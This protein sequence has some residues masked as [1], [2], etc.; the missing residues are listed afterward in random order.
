MARNLTWRREKKALL[1]EKDVPK[2]G[3]LD[4]PEQVKSPDSRRTSFGLSLDINR[5]QKDYIDIIPPKWSAISISLSENKH[6]LCITKMQA[7]QSPFIIRLPLER[8]N[9]RDADNEIFNFQQ[10]RTEI[11]E[12]I[13]LANET[14]HDA[15]DLSIKGAKSA[16][17][18]DRAALD[19]RMKDLLENIENI[20]LGGFKGIFSQHQRRSALLARFQKS[21]QNVLDKHLPSRRQVRGKRGK[22]VAP[23]VTLDPRILELFIG[24]GDATDPECDFDD[25]LNDLLY[26]VV[27]ILQF[28]GERNAYD[29]IDFDSMVVETFDALHSYHSAVKSEPEMEQGA[30]TIL[31]LDKALHVFPWE[32]L[33]CMQ[34]QA[35][36]RVP[37]LACLRRLILEQRS[38]TEDLDAGAESAKPSGHKVSVKSGS[39]I[40]NPGADLKTTQATFEKPLLSLGS[41]WKR[42]VSNKPTEA[43]FETALTDSDVLLYFGHGSGAQ[44]IRGRAIRKMEKC[45]A[46]VLLMGC[47]SARLADVGDFECHGPVWNYMLAGCP[48]VVG[49]LWDV[50]DRDIDRFAGRVF[51]EWGL[52]KKGTFAD[53]D[54]GKDKSKW[55]S[56]AADADGAMH[57]KRKRAATPDGPDAEDGRASLVEAVA[58]ARDA[59]RFRYLTA[60]AVC[61]YGIP[62]YV[63]K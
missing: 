62:V 5:L 14:C 21:F 36:S 54:K 52:L 15:R 37:S 57:A 12:V 41:S 4:W 8:A 40:L 34:G 28:H 48:A 17:W 26:F 33:P 42:I 10:G 53:M 16:W 58:R 1:L 31:I 61:V 39:Y 9:S 45:R 47:S 49:T 3:G 13:R 46:T 25:A 27:D 63:D 38:T 19:D 60:A 29:E 24:L 2:S 11:L 59:C 30:H 56:R 32:S 51:E 6:D 22:S 20:W 23:K 50:T 44:Y 35:V 18:A 43:E 7:D 55:K